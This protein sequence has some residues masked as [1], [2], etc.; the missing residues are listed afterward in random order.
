MHRIRAAFSSRLRRFRGNATSET[1]GSTLNFAPETI[2]NRTNLHQQ[3][4]LERNPLNLIPGS[5]RLSGPTRS[6]PWPSREPQRP[7]ARLQTGA[8]GGR[9]A[10]APKVKLVTAQELLLRLRLRL[11][12]PAILSRW[13]AEVEAVAGQGTPPGNSAAKLAEA[14]ALL[15][16]TSRD[17]TAARRCFELLKS[18]HAGR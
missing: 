12:P 18:I 9:A 7:R 6:T 1:S 13:L 15:P 14:H 10:A 8:V 2:P 3:N 17:T 16:Q 4:G 5:L 11:R